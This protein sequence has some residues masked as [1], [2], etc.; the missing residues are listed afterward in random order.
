[1]F[2]IEV[3]IRE[4]EHP[5]ELLHWLVDSEFALYRRNIHT[6]DLRDVT[7]DLATE[8]ETKTPDEVY[9]CRHNGAHARRTLKIIIKLFANLSKI[10]KL[11]LNYYRDKNITNTSS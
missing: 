6:N 1:M 7:Y 5:A 3:E 9:V 2:E 10:E 11:R 4:S 8:I